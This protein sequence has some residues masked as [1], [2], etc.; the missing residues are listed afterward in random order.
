MSLIWG[1]A[2]KHTYES[3]PQTEPTHRHRK[4][5]YGYQRG[6][7]GGKSYEY[8]INKLYTK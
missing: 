2:K 4:Q 8:G 3:I 6:K 1:G 5:M 7:Q